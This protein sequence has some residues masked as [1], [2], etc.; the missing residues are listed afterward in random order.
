MSPP[1]HYWTMR[2]FDSRMTTDNVVQRAD[3]T[4]GVDTSVQPIFNYV[5]LNHGEILV[6]PEDFGWVKHTSLAAGATVWS[7]GQVGI[8]N[9]Q[10]RLVDLQSGHYVRSR[11]T[12]IMPGS[13]LARR[14]MTFT[15]VVF[16]AYFKTFNL[17]NLHPS[18]QCVWL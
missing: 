15:E 2:S 14:L 3:G 13:N 12:P 18:F 5:I 11:V 4:F 9:N 1:L 7:A 17:V 16:K 6:A 10:P 8:L